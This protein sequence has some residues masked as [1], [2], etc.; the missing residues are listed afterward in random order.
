MSNTALPKIHSLCFL[1]LQIGFKKF[2]ENLVLGNSA[3]YFG[4]FFDINQPFPAF[5]LVMVFFFFQ[6]QQVSISLVQFNV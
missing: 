4:E 1:H 5:P 3:T 6:S 2:Q